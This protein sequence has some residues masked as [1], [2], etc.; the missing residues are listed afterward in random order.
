MFIYTGPSHIDNEAQLAASGP[1]MSH[2]I[3]HG[4]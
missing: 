4:T 3:R 1:E 2:V